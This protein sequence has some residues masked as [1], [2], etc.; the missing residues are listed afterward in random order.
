[1]NELEKKIVTEAILDF[2]K[3]AKK[4]IEKL[5][6]EFGVD[7][8]EKNPFN[9][10]ISIKNNLRKGNLSENWTYWFHGDACEFENSE[11]KQLVYV[12]INRNGNYGVI[13]NYYLYK[14]I[15]T[16]KSL[17]KVSNII[18][19]EKRFNE[20]ILELEKAKIIIDIGENEFIKT[21]V[22]NFN[23]IN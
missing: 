2:D 13:D 16:T 14:F 3:T 6:T 18:S 15:L 9:K 12:K 7:K 4:L 5:L 22:L 20:L 21:R 19:N 11:T 8:K 1:M 17:K 23:K 10:F